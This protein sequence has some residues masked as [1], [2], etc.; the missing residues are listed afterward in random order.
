VVYFVKY[1]LKSLLVYSHMVVNQRTPVQEHLLEELEKFFKVNYA[2]LALIHESKAELI[3][4]ILT[5]VDK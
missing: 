3:F 1:S 2:V 4:L 5:T